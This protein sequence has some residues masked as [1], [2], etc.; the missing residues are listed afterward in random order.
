MRYIFALVEVDLRFLQVQ[1]MRAQYF[2]ISNSE[3][4]GFMELLSSSGATSIVHYSARA[5]DTFPFFFKK[6]N[7]LSIVCERFIIQTCRFH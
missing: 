1:V 7:A 4:K 5:A 3:P 6:K 2:C